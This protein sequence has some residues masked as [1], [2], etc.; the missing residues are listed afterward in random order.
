M[1]KSI[2]PE[3]LNA[4]LSA[5][6]LQPEGLGLDAITNAL[7]LPP[8]RRTLQYQLK[9]LVD[10][11]RITTQGQGRGRKYRSTGIP[12]KRTLCIHEPPSSA[13]PLSTA[14][15][16]I[17]KLVSRPLVARKP[18]GYNIAFLDDY[19]PNKSAYLSP[20][21]RAQLHAIGTPSSIDQPAGTIAA[22]ILSRLLIDLSWNSSRLEGNTY[23][24]LETQRLLIF[25]AEAT[26]TEQL[27]TQMILNHKDAIE[28]LVHSADEIGFNRYTVL[29]LHAYLANNLMPNPNSVGQLRQYPV[30]IGQSVFHPLEVPQLIN[31]YFD[32]ILATASA[33]QD[34]FEQSFF[35]MVHLPYL[36]PFED[37]NK[38][39][40][41][42]VA[43]ISLIKTNR[44]PLSFT[45][46]PTELYVAAML[47]VYEMNSI[48]L[49]KDVFMFAYQ[50]S[51]ERYAAV[52][53]S[54]GQPNL[55][56]LQY[57]DA[58]RTVIHNIISDNMNRKNSFSHLRNWTQMNIPDADQEIFTQ[59]VEEEIMALHEG[60]FA[61]YRV[62]P[63]QFTQWQDTWNN[64]LV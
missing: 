28:F 31:D 15:E 35:T 57:R 30:S 19:K 22:R 49:L 51:A 27:D 43:N 38:R 6:N 58:L 23:S 8:P 1:A 60:N 40:S 12:L 34:P 7:Y 54:I 2:P 53:Q 37:V 17:R 20:E 64:D 61:R 47:G 5:I 52:K 16:R 14:G 39:V 11:G 3:N 18:V 24:L 46:V 13:V 26:G 59:S 55:F 9:H 56:K 44:L 21:E 42:L 32:Q 41:R 48:N 50:R 29:N 4:I 33:I 62:R 63:S 45:D 25:G 10:T 36:Q